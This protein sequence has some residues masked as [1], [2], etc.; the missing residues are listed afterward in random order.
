MYIKEVGLESGFK[1]GQRNL[2]I[3]CY[4]D[5]ANLIPENAKNLQVLLLKVLILKY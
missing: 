4:A 3:P 2:S 1:I 5:A